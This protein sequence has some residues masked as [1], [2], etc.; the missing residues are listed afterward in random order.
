MALFGRLNSL[1]RSTAI[2]Q[3]AAGCVL[4]GSLMSVGCAAPDETAEQTLGGLKNGTSTALNPAVGQLFG[5]FGRCT[6]SL[7]SPRHAVTA[8]HCNL[9]A[10][11]LSGTNT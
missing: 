3:A 8:A 6:A 4:L 9:H 1:I 2:Q 11:A 10:D 7:I 5:N